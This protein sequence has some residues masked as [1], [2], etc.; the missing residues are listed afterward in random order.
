MH[1]E[2]AAEWV[3]ASDRDRL[4]TSGDFAAASLKLSII[5]DDIDS[6][7]DVRPYAEALKKCIDTTYDPVPLV[8]EMKNAT[9]AALCWAIMYS[10][11]VK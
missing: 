4:A 10:H 1:K 11:L 6:L 3:Q 8:P 5:W 2:T 9:A 7:D